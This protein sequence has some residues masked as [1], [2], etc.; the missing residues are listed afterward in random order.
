M[1]NIIQYQEIFIHIFQSSFFERMKGRLGKQYQLFYSKNSNSL[2]MDLV[3]VTLKGV[4]KQ[5]KGK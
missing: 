4:S 2:I 5:G 3:T 1:R